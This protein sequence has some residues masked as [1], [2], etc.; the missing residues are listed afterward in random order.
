MILHVCRK[1][2]IQCLTGSGDSVNLKFPKVVRGVTIAVSQFPTVKKVLSAYTAIF[3]VPAGTVSSGLRVYIGRVATSGTREGP[4][5]SDRL[6][7][8]VTLPLFFNP[9]TVR[10]VYVPES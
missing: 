3:R 5:V 4:A 2:I 8:V 7:S 6:G 10:G 1:T 9:E